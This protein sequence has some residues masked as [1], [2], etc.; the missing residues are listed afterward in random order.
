M[1]FSGNK[2]L[3]YGVKTKITSNTTLWWIDI[4]AELAD[5]TQL[6]LDTHYFILLTCLLLGSLTTTKKSELDELLQV[7]ELSDVVVIRHVSHL[8]RGKW[9]KRR[10][11]REKMKQVLADDV[12]IDSE[13]NKV[14]WGREVKSLAVIYFFRHQPLSRSSRYVSTPNRY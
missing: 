14:S 12:T 10:K 5:R 6:Q 13:D 7:S 11:K 2:M 4:F 8:L 9:K 3:S 1:L